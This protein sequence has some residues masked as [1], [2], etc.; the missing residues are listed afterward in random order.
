MASLISSCSI[1]VR[2]FT[3]RFVGTVQPTLAVTTAAATSKL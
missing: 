1:G 3:G 2:G